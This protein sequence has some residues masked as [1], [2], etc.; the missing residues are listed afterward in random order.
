MLKLFLSGDRRTHPMCFALALLF[1][2]PLALTVKGQCI[3]RPSITSTGLLRFEVVN[4][5]PNV[6]YTWVAAA[7]ST[8]LF[9]GNGHIAE[10]PYPNTNFTLGFMENGRRCVARPVFAIE[11]CESG[12]FTA[13]F[14]N[15]TCSVDFT[16]NNGALLS[17]KYWNF[18]DGS[19]VV[20][21][22][23][24][25]TNHAY[26][27]PGGTFNVTMWQIDDYPA[28]INIDR[29]T[30]SVKVACTPV[31]EETFECCV[32][33][34]RVSGG[35]PE[36]QHYWEVRNI[37][38][39]VCASFNTP[40]FEYF[41]TNF[42]TNVIGGK[43]KI[44]HVVTCGG[45]QILDEI[46]DYEIKNK[47]I[48]VGNPTAPDVVPLAG[49]TSLLND[50]KEVFPLNTIYEGRITLYGT[51]NVNR[52]TVFQ[53]ADVC[54]VECEGINLLDHLTLT[55]SNAQLH[56]PPQCNTWR[57]IDVG[58]EATIQISGGKNIVQGA[59]YGIRSKGGNPLFNLTDVT[60]SNN[61]VGLLIKHA[62]RQQLVLSRCVFQ[63]AGGL[64]PLCGTIEDE[65]VN[66]LS[67]GIY[68]PSLGFAGVVVMGVQPSQDRIR[69]AENTF[70]NLANGIWLQNSKTGTGQAGISGNTFVQITQSSLYGP[71]S[72]GH[73]VA[74]RHNN[75]SAFA[76][77]HN[78]IFNNCH[79][80][81]LGVSEGAGS[82]ELKVILNNF[83]TVNTG[84]TFRQNTG[85]NL[86]EPRCVEN[87][88]NSLAIGI[89]VHKVRNIR[90]LQNSLRGGGL[91]ISVV[92]SLNSLIE[93]NRLSTF[94]IGMQ[95]AGDCLSPDRIKCNAFSQCA[96]ALYLKADAIIG[97]QFSTGNRWIGYQNSTLTGARHDG[98]IA[99][100]L[101]ETDQN[102]DEYPYTF[103][104][105]N[106]VVWFQPGNLVGC[107]PNLREAG[108]EERS[109][110]AY[111]DPKG[112]IS[113]FP[114]PTTGHIAWTGLL[115]TPVT[116][117]V[118]NLAGQLV[119]EIATEDKQLD[120]G[121]L[122]N[123]LY[124][125]RLFDQNGEVLATQKLFKTL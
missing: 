88:I 96:T 61:Y 101:F 85:G 55:L 112:Y 90:V 59:V 58:A 64:P 51:L 1:V 33:K 111:T 63:T 25:P 73:G 34:L 6:A 99:T 27:Y 100:S 83:N 5:T 8:V 46:H 48:Y 79:H 118:F 23:A 115:N 102:S 13:D 110:P 16:P 14:K 42:N 15:S 54:I 92:E 40:V 60:F 71:A 35:R 89:D 109:T 56:Q 52:T 10:F 38:D 44:R 4:P 17:E 95:F 70:S 21:S 32:L 26:A 78:N 125:I 94:Q 116:V 75:G 76:Q 86:L 80:G 91:G 24:V 30:K 57:G 3:V 2:W 121:R 72:S 31:V 103:Q 29:C 114:N 87:T 67:N 66:S 19:P 77:I 22:N 81:V 11:Y 120:L 68:D 62:P 53:N 124:I 105:S 39:Q 69:I 45:T 113:I 20:L 65:G 50:G 82:A 122:E 98:N 12:G 117:K 123:G 28:G 43:I 7:N 104:A 36:C 49:T 18:G 84:I 119:E 93:G 108:I 74:F 41:P 9:S 107:V 106:P 47:G 37:S 97:S